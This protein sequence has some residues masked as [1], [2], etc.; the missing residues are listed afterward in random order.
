MAARIDALS[1]VWVAAVPATTTHTH[2]THR[3]IMRVKY[4]IGVL[5]LL[6]QLN[7]LVTNFIFGP[8][9]V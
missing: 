1:S 7:W 2:S 3:E 8:S 5:P 9:N 4:L 6:P